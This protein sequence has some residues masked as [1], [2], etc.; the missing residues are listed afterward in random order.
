V[1][2]RAVG[3]AALFLLGLV[4]APAAPAQLPSS[5]DA[6]PPWE[7]NARAGGSFFPS[8]L[9]AFDELSIG[10]ANSVTYGGSIGRRYDVVTL[11]VSML[12]VPADLKASFGELDAAVDH[13]LTLI[14]LDMLLNLNTS[15][16]I[17][18]FGAIGI[19]LKVYRPGD[20]PYDDAVTDGAF[21]IGLG[22]RYLLTQLFAIRAEVRDYISFYRL[23]SP[24]AGSSAQHDILLTV[25]ISVRL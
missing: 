22:S 21:N 8:S 3:I 15:G 4:A 17:E 24:G 25:G 13:G 16:R 10:L 11:E 23:E 20:R 9:V 14:S 1:K 5:A 6:H 18:P 12:W 19:G 7:F 2:T